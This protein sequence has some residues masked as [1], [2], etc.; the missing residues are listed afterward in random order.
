M[1]INL[2]KNI[3]YHYS[4][5][6]TTKAAS[7]YG[8]RCKIG[9]LIIKK[10]KKLANLI[11]IFNNQVEIR[12]KLIKGQGP[13]IVISEDNKNG[14]SCYRQKL[15]ATSESIDDFEMRLKKVSSVEF[16]TLEYINLLE[17]TD[18]YSR[19]ME[20]ICFS[21]REMKNVVMNSYH[22]YLF[23]TQLLNDLDIK[24]NDFNR[25]KILLLSLSQKRYYSIYEAS[26]YCLKSMGYK[27]DMKDTLLIMDGV[28]DY[29]N[30]NYSFDT[31]WENLMKDEIA[32]NE[33]LDNE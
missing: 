10:R 20:E 26:S 8:N 9:K 17:L 29:T 1:L 16:L 30:V 28:K 7:T 2:K 12:E 18:N 19:T 5:K 13:I 27:V 23:K 4:Q 3:D 14:F 15:E 22:L 32:I 24:K 11:I 6:N 21:V 25:G 33:Y 31:R